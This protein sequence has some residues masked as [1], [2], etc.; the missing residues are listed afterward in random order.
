M[1]GKPQIDILLLFLLEGELLSADF[2]HTASGE[3]SPFF[4]GS[5]LPRISA[6]LSS[7]PNGI[8]KWGLEELIQS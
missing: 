2:M 4:S 6:Q 5:P 7:A 1:V 3:F 8:K